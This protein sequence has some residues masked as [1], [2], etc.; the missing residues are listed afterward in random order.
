[1]RQVVSVLFAFVTQESSSDS[2][3]LL[4]GLRYANEFPKIR[5]A[6]KA[7]MGVIS[8]FYRLWGLGCVVG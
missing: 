2:R 5:D 8:G 7:S 3:R 6:S 1:M 4:G